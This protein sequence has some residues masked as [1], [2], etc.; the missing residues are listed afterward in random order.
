M[1]GVLPVFLTL[2]L[3]VMDSQSITFFRFASAGV[4]LLLLLVKQ[5]ALPSVRQLPVFMLGVLVVA[6]LSLTLNYVANVYGLLFISAESAQLLMQLAP[7]LLMIGGVLCYR[8]TMSSW[9]WLGTL[10][11]VVGLM[12]FFHQKWPVLWAELTAAESQKSSGQAWGMLVIL[13]AALSWVAYALLQRPLMRVLTVPQLNM[14]LY[15]LGACFLLPFA[16]WSPLMTLSGLTLFA[17]LFCCA[18]TLIAYGAFTKALQ[19]WPAA[20]VGAVLALS[21]LFTLLSVQL[22]AYFWASPIEVISP[23]AYVGAAL[24]VAGSMLAA[25]GRR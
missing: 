1:W 20:K 3:R 18:N 16:S 5:R 14:L 7:L 11:L 15:L 23:L 13:F 6:A 17:L 12:L 21:P 9:Q 22:A 25:L 24:V 2:C 10:I 4:L 8:E 19:I